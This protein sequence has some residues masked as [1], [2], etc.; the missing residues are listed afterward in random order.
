MSNEVPESQQQYGSILTILGENA[1]QNGKLLNK[2]IEFTHIAFGD[3]NDTYAQ[4]DRKSNALINELHRMPIN[5]VDVLQPTPESVPMLKVEAILPDDVND[6]VIREFAAVASFNGQ[7]YFH[8]IG[9]CA[10]V[11]IPSPVNNGNVSTPVTV[12]MIFVITSSEPIVEIDPNVI[13]AS[14]T[15]VSEEVNKQTA[16]L[17]DQGLLV[18]KHGVYGDKLSGVETIQVNGYPHGKNSIWYA[19]DKPE[20]TMI[21]FVDNND[22]GTVKVIT[23]KGEYEFLSKSVLEYRAN[24]IFDGW[25]ADGTGSV[26]CNNAL[27]KV[28]A[29][30]P[31]QIIYLLPDSTYY[32][33]GNRPDLTGVR[34]FAYDG[35]E[36]KVDANPNIKEMQLLTDV[37]INNVVHLTNIKKHRNQQNEYLVASGN[38]LKRRCISKP[39]VLPFNDA[40]VLLASISNVASFGSFTGHNSGT[41]IGWNDDFSNNQ[42]G[43]FVDVEEGVLFECAYRHI[44]TAAGTNSEFRGPTVISGNERVDFAVYVGKPIAKLISQPGTVEEFT[45]PNGGA[46]SLATDGS[47]LMGVRVVDSVAEYYVN[48]TL[49]A[50]HKFSKKP[51]KLGFLTSWQSASQ[52][53]IL[54]MTK[55][56]QKEAVSSKPIS[57]A[58]V[59]DSISYGAWSTDSYDQILKKTLEH[60]GIGDV[61]TVNYAVSGSATSNWK[62]GG[63][64]DITTKD[65]S[66]VDYCLVMLGTNDVQGGVTGPVFEANLREIL[67]HLSSVNVIP[68]LGVFPVWTKREVSGVHGVT[69]Q[70]YEKGGWHRQIVRYLAAELGLYVADVCANFGANIGWYGDNIH[71]TEYGQIAVAAAFAEPIITDLNGSS[72]D[73][74]LWKDRVVMPSSSWVAIDGY[75]NPVISIKNNHV[76]VSGAVTGGVNNST[77]LQLP[78]YARPTKNKVFTVWCNDDQSTPGFARITVEPDGDVRLSQATVTPYVVFLDGIN[79][80]N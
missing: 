8:A 16:M 18:I 75:D 15:W 32:F 49:F 77:I 26:T 78:D 39:E 59:G 35:A 28:K 14:R 80:R 46:Y 3:A 21:D 57:I 71:P 50:K 43:A 53:Q 61:T 48:G 31:N 55:T 27:A 7:S 40:S 68:I 47:V 52:C 2:Q 20:G 37:I 12:E 44:G 56:K 33:D 42:E 76:M 22:Y 17:S 73:N 23:D 13:T 54:N 11:Y 79:Y 66:G 19:W 9:N 10:R 70:N 72:T 41:Y 63:T 38:A 6:V 5:S 25:G 1:E 69:T 34:W 62:A 4:P 29:E 45:L 74:Y 30:K 58:I 67:S 64:I 24:N 36:I 51:T 60:A 65:F